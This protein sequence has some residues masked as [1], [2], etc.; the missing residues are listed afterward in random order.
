MKIGKWKRN[1]YLFS[2]AFLSSFLSHHYY[3]SASDSSF[4]F[5]RLCVFSSTS[6][7]L[8]EFFLWL[9][10]Y[11][12]PSQ[13]LAA[14]FEVCPRPPTHHKRCR[15]EC[16]DEEEKRSKKFAQ[17]QFSPYECLDIPSEKKINVVNFSRVVVS[18]ELWIVNF[19]SQLRASRVV[20]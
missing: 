15:W 2:V 4:S 12:P 18:S 5:F 11:I 3:P 20:N 7:F 6:Q 10:L 19:S 13:P 8:A 14:S 9:F 17:L 16:G 1:F